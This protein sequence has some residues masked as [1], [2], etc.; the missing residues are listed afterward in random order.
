MS[1]PHSE[2]ILPP[3]ASVRMVTKLL[4][5]QSERGTYMSFPLPI[6]HFLGSCALHTCPV[7]LDLEA[8]NRSQ[9]KGK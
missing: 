8:T 1:F 4:Q 6:G 3:T 7:I 2:G 5:I 9:P